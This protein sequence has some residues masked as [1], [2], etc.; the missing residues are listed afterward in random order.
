MEE[1]S[2]VVKNTLSVGGLTFLG[3]L[4]GFRFGVFGFRVFFLCVLVWFQVCLFV[5]LIC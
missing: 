3:G 1:Q 5:C 2:S 4:F